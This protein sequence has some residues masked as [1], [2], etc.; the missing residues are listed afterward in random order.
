M[1][2]TNVFLDTNILI[3]LFDTRDLAKHNAAKKLIADLQ[4]TSTLY[5]SLQVV[6]EFSSAIIS[7]ISKPMS[8]DKLGSYYD[9]FD[10]IFR[11]VPLTMDN[12]RNA[13]RIK[14]Q[15]GL[16]TVQEV[17]LFSTT[18]VNSS[19]AGIPCAVELDLPVRK[20]FRTGKSISFQ[21]SQNCGNAIFTFFFRIFSQVPCRKCL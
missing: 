11:I 12:S 9:L 7:K 2:E 15:Y 5:I 18:K 17:L 10:D 6:N 21:N 14:A 4:K 3:Y 1:S 13:I 16:S 8:L 20:S 19:C